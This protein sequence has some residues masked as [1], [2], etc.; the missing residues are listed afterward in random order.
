M[1]ADVI[2]IGAGPSGMMAAMTAAANGAQTLILE[3][4]ERAGRKLAITG[5]GRCNLTNTAPLRDYE[6]QIV[7]NPRFMLSALNRFTNQDVM[8]YFESMGVRLKV[9]RGQRVFP[10]SDRAYDI[11]DALVEGCLRQR[12]RFLYRTVVETVERTETGFSIVTDKGRYESRRLIIAAGGRSYPRT[13]STGDGYRWAADLGIHVLEP[14][15]ALVPLLC[16]EHW[17]HGLQGLALKNV[18]I[19]I[20]D[21]GSKKPLFTDFGEMLFTHFG[22]SGPIILSASSFLQ[23]ARASGRVN[24]DLTLHID[25]KPA[26]DS[27]TLKRRILRDIREQGRKQLKT[28]LEGL[29]PKR[30]ITVILNQSG[31]DGEQT[32]KTLTDRQVDV[33][34]EQLKNLSC[35]IRGFGSFDEAII[36]QGGV[37]VRD[38]HPKT[39]ESKSVPGLYFV[40]EILDVDA[41]TGGFNLQIAFS[42]GYAGGY[43]AAGGV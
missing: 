1:D 6:E 3:R 28:V 5:K 25:L 33:L 14:Q 19:S 16:P 21:E 41:L 15:P 4:N 39:M 29:L 36:T 18:R 34:T 11:V 35:M 30:M 12:V 24:G 37:D 9:E 2:V 17:V 23:K 43:F 10:V 22:V 32:A 27:E 40:G 13:G 20:D 8:N 7:S 38:I 31:L 26:L 42:T